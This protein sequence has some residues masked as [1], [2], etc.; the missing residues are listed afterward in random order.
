MAIP[1]HVVRLAL[2]SPAQPLTFYR[3]MHY[4]VQSAVLRSHVVRLSVGDIGG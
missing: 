1:D 2:P 3:A 4:I